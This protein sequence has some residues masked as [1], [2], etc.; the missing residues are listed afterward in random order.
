M[1]MCK[2]RSQ[3]RLSDVL[4]ISLLINASGVVIKAGCIMHSF[5]SSSVH[6][7]IV[8]LPPSGLNKAL[9]TCP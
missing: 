9:E 4:L 2:R 7:R 1:P 3:M 6:A 8:I 5:H